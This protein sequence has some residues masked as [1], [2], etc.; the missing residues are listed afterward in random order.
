M[1]IFIIII[2]YCLAVIAYAI[3]QGK[4]K[5]VR[6]IGDKVKAYLFVDKNQI[7]S[8]RISKKARK[9]DY[10]YINKK[11]IAFQVD[12]FVVLNKNF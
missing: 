8:I 1:S 3:R 11:K 5:R 6:K 12:S 7:R 9:L 4:E 10:K 2:Q